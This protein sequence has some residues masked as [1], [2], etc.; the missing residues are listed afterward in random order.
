MPTINQLV[1]KPRVPKRK[2][3]KSPALQKCPQRSAS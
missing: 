1:R 2:R 3:S